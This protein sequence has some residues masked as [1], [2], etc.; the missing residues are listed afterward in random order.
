MTNKSE[1]RSLPRRPF[2]K[3]VDFELKR[4]RPGFWESID[5]R[6]GTVDISSRGLGLSTD[7]P[8]AAGEIL[9]INLPGNLKGISIPVLSEVRW[10]HSEENRYRAGLQFLS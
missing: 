10:V 8:L 1:M 4:V 7:I 3:R 5:G 6:G 2:N 9:K